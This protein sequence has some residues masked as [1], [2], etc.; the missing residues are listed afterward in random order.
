[1]IAINYLTPFSEMRFWGVTL[2]KYLES[3][4]N[5]GELCKLSVEDKMGI[6]PQLVP[7]SNLLVVT[8]KLVPSFPIGSYPSILSVWILSVC[9]FIRLLVRV[10]MSPTKSTAKRFLQNLKLSSYSIKKAFKLPSEPARNNNNILCT[11]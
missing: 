8:C 9:L 6:S 2:G 10:V 11:E 1:M 4:M 7:V 5:S 3:F